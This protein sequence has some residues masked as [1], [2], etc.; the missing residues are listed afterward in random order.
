MRGKGE[1][2]ERKGEWRR[3]REGEGEREGELESWGARMIARVVVVKRAP[4]DD[5]VSHWRKMH[6]V[7]HTLLKTCGGVNI[8]RRRRL[9]GFAGHIARVPE[10][11]LYNALRT[12]SLSWWRAFQSRKLVKHP[13]RFSAWRWEQQFEDLYGV[14]ASIFVDEDVGWRALASDRGT[15]R[16][17]QAL[18]AQ[19]NDVCA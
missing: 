8:H 3:G 6:R 14:E 19:R 15:W 1:C 11:T 13:G 10:G 2:G 18:F 7:G 17:Q 4:D 12:R 16:A 9:H 5:G